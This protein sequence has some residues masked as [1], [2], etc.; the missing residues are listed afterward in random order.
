MK[1]AYD[2]VKQKSAVDMK[3]ADEKWILCAKEMPIK[4]DGKVVWFSFLGEIPDKNWCDR[5]IYS[6]EN[7]WTT[8]DAEDYC[9]DGFAVPPVAWMPDDIPVPYSVK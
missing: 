7:G 3:T 1:Q 9:L 6:R 2:Q 5:F 4:E 8:M